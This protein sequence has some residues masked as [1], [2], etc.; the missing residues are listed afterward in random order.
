MGRIISHHTL[1]DFSRVVIIVIV[2]D[3]SSRRRRSWPSSWR[4]HDWPRLLDDVLSAL[5][6]YQAVFAALGCP[7]CDGFTVGW[8]KHRQYSRLAALKLLSGGV[9]DVGLYGDMPPRLQ[10]VDVCYAVPGGQVCIRS[11]TCQSG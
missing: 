2:A 8:L 4:Q 7:N 5:L 6:I 10:R 9:V 1:D 3:I 11:S